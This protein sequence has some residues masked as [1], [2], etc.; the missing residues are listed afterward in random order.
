[1]AFHRG[2][3]IIND[4]LVL[5]VDTAD[6]N[7][8]T[9]QP[10]TNLL[11]YTNNFSSSWTPYCGPATNV[12][13]NTTDITDPLGTNTAF[14][15]V[16]SA[17]TT[18]TN[19]EAWGFFYDPAVP[20]ITSGKTYTTSFYAR[21]AVG[22]ET[23]DYGVNDG[24]MTYSQ[25]LTTTWTR[26]SVSFGNVTNTTRGF[27]FRNA[28]G[29]C[30]YY[31]WG[32]QTVLGSVAGTFVPSVGASN[33]TLNL[34]WKDIVGLNNGTFNNAPVYSTSN[35]GIM[36]F[37]GVDDYVSVP[38]SSSLQVADTFTICAWIKASSL[39]GRFGIFSTRATNPSG[40]WQFEVG[41]GNAGTNRITL[42]GLNTYIADSV[43]NA[44]A[45][46]SWY[47]ICVVK[48]N[49]ATQGA[50]FY[51]N[52]QVVNNNSTAAYT[53]SNNTDEKRIGIGTGSAQYFSGSIAQVLVYNRALSSS[54]ILQNFNSLRTRFF[55]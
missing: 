49:N 16:R 45:T 19:V 39:S 48:T 30:T 34:T 31:V 38:N 23:L 36:T 52:G 32:P 10:V 9:G 22:G 6:N 41:T 4:G 12:T 29:S 11:T 54:D 20:I 13:Y 21:G 42:T 43:D 47:H 1:M 37:D 2:P 14:K 44:I 24:Y 26:Y 55:I 46:N 3:R 25:A 27:Q 5:C 35:V 15:I 53:I 7:S 8:C 28:G 17:N 40:A 51:V 33:G 50:V 18:C